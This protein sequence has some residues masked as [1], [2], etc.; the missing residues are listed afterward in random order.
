MKI[1]AHNSQ[2][3]NQ[4]SEE[5][6]LMSSSEPFIENSFEREDIP[7]APPSPASLVNEKDLG[8]IHDQETP[9]PAERDSLCSDEWENDDDLGYVTI[10]LSEQEFF[11]MEEVS[12][13][14]FLLIEIPGG[15]ISTFF[16]S[17]L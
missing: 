16:N 12:T 14:L 5:T 1:V 11:E 10:Q 2:T 9:S 8:N 3:V 6:N 13:V 7:P 17:K 4:K 15:C